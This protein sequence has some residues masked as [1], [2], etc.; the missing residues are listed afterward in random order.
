MK[1]NKLKSALALW[2]CIGVCSVCAYIV[3]GPKMVAGGLG[4]LFLLIFIGLLVA[5]EDK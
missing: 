1:Q 2:A 5:E 3:G 4:V